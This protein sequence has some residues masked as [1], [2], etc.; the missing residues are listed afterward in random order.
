LIGNL[1]L[2]ILPEHRENSSNTK[3]FKQPFLR[4]LEKYYYGNSQ[5][6][7]FLTKSIAHSV[8]GN[9]SLFCFDPQTSTCCFVQIYFQAVF[10]PAMNLVVSLDV[11]GCDVLRYIHTT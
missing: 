2:N 6:T 5:Q 7:P 9:F 4:C 3:N 10:S 11:N 8:S 1:E